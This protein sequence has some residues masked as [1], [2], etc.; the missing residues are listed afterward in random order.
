MSVLLQ[1]CLA[2]T[3]WSVRASFMCAGGH[4]LRRMSDN[5]VA[6]QQLAGNVMLNK[7]GC[8]AG[9]LGTTCA[10]IPAQMAERAL[11]NIR[12]EVNQMIV[13]PPNM[14]PNLAPNL[15]SPNAALLNESFDVDSDSFADDV[16]HD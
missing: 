16:L 10:E 2:R 5:S 14:A 7:S 11:E 3:T 9:S 15:E 1:N 8:E 4:V 6:I 12:K 13:F